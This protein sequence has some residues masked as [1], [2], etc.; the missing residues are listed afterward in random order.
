M[1]INKNMKLRIQVHA[2]REATGIPEK[3]EVL[4]KLGSEAQVECVKIEL[5]SQLVKN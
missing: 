2:T 5:Y 4:K 3:L 1:L